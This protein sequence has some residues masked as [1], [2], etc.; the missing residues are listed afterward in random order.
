M[1]PTVDPFLQDY[2]ALSGAIQGRF[3]NFYYEYL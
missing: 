2:V 3:L 1:P